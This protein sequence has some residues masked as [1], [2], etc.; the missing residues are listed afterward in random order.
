M[1]LELYL[2]GKTWWFK[3]RIDELPKSQYYRQSTGKT[4]KAHARTFIEN[5]R[6]H[7]IKAHYVGVEKS[8]IFADAV[9]LYNPSPDF[10]SYLLKVMPYIE[11]MQVTDITP[12]MVR[13]L[14]PKIS[15]KNSTETWHKQIIVPV[16]AVINYAH[17]LGHCPPIKIKAFSKDKRQ[18]QDRLRGKLSRV[19]KEPGNWEWVMAFKAAADPHTGL[20]CQ[21]IFETAARIGQAVRIKHE[22]LDTTKNRIFMPEAKGAAAC[23]V[24]ISPE[25]AGE[26]ESLPPKRPKHQI[27][28]DR[29]FEP[30]MFGYQN[31]DSVYKKWKRICRNAEIEVIMP[32]AAGRHGFATELLVRHKLDPRTVAD[33]G[34]W[35]DPSLLLKTY[36]HSEDTDQKVQ[37]VLRTGRVQ[38]AQQTALK[39]LNKKENNDE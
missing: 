24:T 7:E 3:G 36:A 6:N 33:A 1:P 19:K 27:H 38:A 21:F 4:E 14:G 39:A 11:H 13:D 34:R 25:L 37:E 5:F 17:D 2:R 15:P 35:A 20:L 31:R 18:Q 8:F 28:S 26:L 16:R 10:A 32:H 22:H 9:D 29:Q 23:W 30:R 12:Q